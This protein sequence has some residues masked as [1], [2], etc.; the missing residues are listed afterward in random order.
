MC[1]PSQTPHAFGP[2]GGAVPRLRFT[3]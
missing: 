1:R 3:E 2:K